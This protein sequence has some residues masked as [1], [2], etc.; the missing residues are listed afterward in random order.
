MPRPRGGARVREVGP[1]RRPPVGFDRGPAASPPTSKSRALAEAWL[2]D[3]G[4]RPVVTTLDAVPPPGREGRSSRR[5]LPRGERAAGRRVCRRHRVG[6]ASSRRLE[7]DVRG[8]PRIRPARRPR[9]AAVRPR[10][11]GDGPRAR[12]GDGPGEL[13]VPVGHGVEQGEP[14]LPRPSWRNAG[15][16]CFGGCSHMPGT[17]RD[18][19]TGERRCARDLGR[20]AEALRR[21]GRRARSGRRREAAPAAGAAGT[22]LA[23]PCLPPEHRRGRAGRGRR[24][25][26]GSARPRGCDVARIA[27]AKAGPRRPRWAAA[28]AGQGRVRPS[29]APRGREGV[30]AAPPP[31]RSRSSRAPE[32]SR[33]S[34]SRRHSATTRTS[35][36]SL[37]R[38]RRPG[39]SR[40]T[41]I[42]SPGSASSG[43]SAATPRASR[44]RR[45]PAR[46]GPRRR[47][48]PSPKKVSAT[49]STRGG[50]ATP[51][52]SGSRAGREARRSGTTTVLRG[53]AGRRTRP[54]PT[55]SSL[56]ALVVVNAV[57][58]T[59]CLLAGLSLAFDSGGGTGAMAA[60]VACAAVGLVAGQAAF[61]LH[62]RCRGGR[63]VQIGLAVLGLPL[64]PFWTAASA[65][66][67]VT[68]LALSGRSS[69]K[70][71]GGVDAG[72]RRRR[73]CAPSALG[74]AHGVL[75]H[76]ALPP[77]GAG[78]R[79]PD[80]TADRSE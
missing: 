24:G 51:R 37:P 65:W 26:K 20:D 17:I 76:R 77:P 12:P 55:P 10:L 9:R 14:H 53:E 33:S 2:T 78:G 79:R 38:R 56:A 27:E 54:L 16:A 58:G 5:P 34:T 61:L 57:T 25:G 71:R 13:P 49:A 59:V 72:G 69:R 60:G 21:H 4:L 35:T 30:G 47:R 23:D 31:A 41:G 80:R 45:R 6:R 52:R 43:A 15:G 22:S 42:V 66:T 48:P 3:L 36:S 67:L 29:A 64:F 75:R 1:G 68:M 63:L 39:P 7:R 28:R 11:A 18:S 50:G 19:R 70:A 8:D 73:P 46:R 62:R 74:P 32:G 40:L 44:P